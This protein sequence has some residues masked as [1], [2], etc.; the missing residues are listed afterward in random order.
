MKDKCP[1]CGKVHHLAFMDIWLVCACGATAKI[2]LMPD[3]R[4][5]IGWM[6]PSEVRQISSTYAEDVRGLN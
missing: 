4:L 6:E 2:A 5:I 1:F 3:G